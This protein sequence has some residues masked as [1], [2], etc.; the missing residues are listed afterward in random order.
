MASE[1]N[2]NLIHGRTEY[3]E[4]LVTVIKEHE[5]Q[6]QEITERL[7]KIIQKLNVVGPV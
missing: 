2:D 4:L 3:L 7:Q 1:D 6:L 5:K